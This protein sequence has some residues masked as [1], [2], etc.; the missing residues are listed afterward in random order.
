M[1]TAGEGVGEIRLPGS[2]NGLTFRNKALKFWLVVTKLT[3]RVSPVSALL[4]RHCE[5]RVLSGFGR[6]YD[7]VCLAVSQR[8]ALCRLLFQFLL[9][10]LEILSA[11]LITVT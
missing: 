10:L 9:L 6:L 5:W 4:L 8:S 7:S 11:P 2:Y 1:A 3:T